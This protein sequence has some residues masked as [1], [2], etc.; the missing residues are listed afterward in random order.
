MRKFPILKCTTA[1]VNSKDLQDLNAWILA[2]QDPN[3]LRA[4]LG[5]IMLSLNSL[6]GVLYGAK[7]SPESMQAKAQQILPDV[8]N[9]E[10]LKQAIPSVYSAIKSIP[11][12]AEDSGS[13]NKNIK[14]ILSR[15]A[16]AIQLSNVLPGQL[17]RLQMIASGAAIPPQSK[18]AESDEDYSE[19]EDANMQLFLKNQIYNAEN[20]SKK[21]LTVVREILQNACDAAIKKASI[22]PGQK[23][24]I[25]VYVHRDPNTKLLDIVAEDNGIGMDW[26]VL[27][28]KFFRY[29]ASGKSED[30]ESTGGYGIAKAIIQ[31][32]PKEGWS[33]ETNG[34][35]ASK[36]DKSMYMAESPTWRASPQG[37]YAPSAPQIGVNP[38][39]TT[40]SLFGLPYANEY[41]IQ[42]LCRNFAIGQVSIV[43]NDQPLQP[44]IV[45][46]ETTIL[47]SGLENLGKSI[48][49]NETEE[50]VAN[51][52]VQNSLKKMP[53]DI[54]N[55]NWDKTS[56]SFA[57]KPNAWAGEMYVLLNG[58]FQFVSAGLLFRRADIICLVKTSARPNEEDYPLDPGRGNLRSPYKEEVLRLATDLK[59][60]MQ[61]ISDNKL[62][63]DGLNISIYNK[64][65]TPIST[66]GAEE[67]AAKEMREAVERT[68]KSAPEL[69][70]APT[71][72]Q[73]TQIREEI[74][75]SIQ[76]LV[77]QQGGD[78]LQNEIV[79]AAIDA[80]ETT[81]PDVYKD[82]DRIIDAVSTPTA[83]VIQRNF[84]SQE[85]VDEHPEL[86]KSLAA[87]W[88]S[89]IRRVIKQSKKLHGSRNK[90]A[91]PGLIF[92]DECIA[93]YIPP[94]DRTGNHIIGINPISLTAL[95]DPELL[96][97]KDKTIE[98]QE[99]ARIGEQIPESADIAMSEK[100]ASFLHHEA[101]HEVTH[102]L[103][104]EGYGSEVFHSKV[105]KMEGLCHF[106][107]KDTKADV[108]KFLRGY[109]SETKK[110]MKL[111]HAFRTPKDLAGGR[112]SSQVLSAAEQKAI[113]MANLPKELGG[114]GLSFR[115]IEEAL[116][117]E[118]NKRFNLKSNRGMEAWRIIERY[119]KTHGPKASTMAW[120]KTQMRGN[121]IRAWINGE[122]SRTNGAT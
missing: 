28:K 83:I 60:I 122:I 25:K 14:M 18:N 101:I 80:M 120:I 73:E 46:A 16:H 30:R 1:A 7:N 52:I 97:G 55:L 32:T 23:P 10:A 24:E 45:L 44:S 35:H 105:S 86:L 116:D 17:S 77:T 95:V 84:T 47:S 98:F 3:Q 109:K 57:V 27:S 82:I 76:A 31:E 36:F 42:Q 41:S 113:Y 91:I 78:K 53:I 66:E 2:P 96:T 56:I 74:T 114:E 48:A 5:R 39:G 62:F 21:T 71:A 33:I 70:S 15:M 89:I 99:K 12:L 108:S 37:R 110:L 118:G 107:Y 90:S 64:N 54:G 58:Q 4:I 100:V 119:K 112:R 92:S 49:K 65:A 106:L 79:A 38:A 94:Q 20:D 117:A 59:Q 50:D 43:F 40:I 19:S 63:E 115:Q 75:K 29:F 85:I 102:F 61:E 103:F 88:Q 26:K 81:G 22:T 6:A 104:P 8:Q 67:P 13:S 87:L 93:V 9:I 72:E 69:F 34:L 111:I 121:Q 68:L 11:D 51:Q